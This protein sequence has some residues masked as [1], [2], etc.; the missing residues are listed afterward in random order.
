[1]LAGLSTEVLSL[2]S[3]CVLLASF[4][5]AVLLGLTPLAKLEHFLY[6]PLL[7]FFFVVQLSNYALQNY[8]I[9]RQDWNGSVGDAFLPLFMSLPT[10]L[11]LSLGV[12]RPIFYF[13]QW[14]VKQVVNYIK[15]CL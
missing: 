5:F 15:R 3:F 7:C 6:V 2:L 10:I 12:L 1:M 11:L 9:R 14:L 8:L 13:S 4:V